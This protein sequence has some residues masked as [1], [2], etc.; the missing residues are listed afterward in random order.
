MKHTYI[1][2]THVYCA[3]ADEIKYLKKEIILWKWNEMRNE[4][5]Q[6]NLESNRLI[7]D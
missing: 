6:I 2:C 4:H 1:L 3:Y 7:E 5:L